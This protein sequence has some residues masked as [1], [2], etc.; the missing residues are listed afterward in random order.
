MHAGMYKAIGEGKV[1]Q[2]SWLGFFCGLC[3]LVGKYKE[4]KAIAPEP[5]NIKVGN[6]VERSMHILMD[7]SHPVAWDCIKDVEITD[8]YCR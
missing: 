3:C 8:A 5:D 7:S 1:R 4:A 2:G 6:P